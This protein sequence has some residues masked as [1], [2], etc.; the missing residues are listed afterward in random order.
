MKKIEAQNKAFKVVD[1][2]MKES[3]SKSISAY[4]IAQLTGVS[5]TTIGRLKRHEQNPTLAILIQIV[6]IL[7][8]SWSEIAKILDN[9]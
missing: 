2:L 8:I 5:D 4:R 9:D 7:D 6:D 3:K 1:F